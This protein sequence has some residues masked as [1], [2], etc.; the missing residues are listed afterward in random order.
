MNKD[1]ENFNQ[2]FHEE[3]LIRAISYCREKSSPGLDGIEYRMIKM[4]S[5]CFKQLLKIFNFCFKEGY[6]MRQ[7]KEVQTIFIVKGNKEDVRPISMILCRL[8]YTKG[9]LMKD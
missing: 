8:K 9:W 4:L 6:I 2:L 1:R 7:W 3:E 5:L